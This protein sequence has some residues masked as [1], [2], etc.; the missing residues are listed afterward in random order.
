MTR[1]ASERRA[2]RSRSMAV[3]VCA[4]ACTVSLLYVGA[5]AF[6]KGVASPP[7]SADLPPDVRRAPLPRPSAAVS[8][9]PA[10]DVSR[11]EVPANADLAL[12]W[13]F[14]V[15]GRAQFTLR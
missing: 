13:S 7:P 14:D 9:Q 8:R 10:L 4:Y 11:S 5:F 2:V 15:E 3:L 6:V 12:P 1:A